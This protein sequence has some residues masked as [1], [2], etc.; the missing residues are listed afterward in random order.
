MAKTIDDWRAYHDGIYDGNPEY[1][2][3]DPAEIETIIGKVPQNTWHMNALRW[4]SELVGFGS[5][6]QI[7]CLTPQATTSLLKH[8]G[9][10]PEALKD[11]NFKYAAKTAVKDG[12]RRYV[13][14]VRANSEGQVVNALS[15]N[16]P[17]TRPK[18]E[19]K[20]LF[21]FLRR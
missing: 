19:K 18:P 14:V 7:T 5:C 10:S 21:G 13:E 17:E 12:A 2:D 15:I 20:S 8:L 3:I 1:R 6:P 16:M 4:G 11:A 9:F